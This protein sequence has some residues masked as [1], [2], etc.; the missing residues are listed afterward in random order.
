M[1]KIAKAA[2]AVVLVLA[3]TVSVFAAPSVSRGPAPSVSKSAASTFGVQKAIVTDAAGNTIR[4][5]P[6]DVT[7]SAVDAATKDEL[8]N[9]ANDLTALVSN[10]ADELPEGVAASD[11]TVKEVYDVKLSATAKKLIE[12]GGSVRIHFTVPGVKKGNFVVVLHKG[13]DGWEAL[14]AKAVGL[15]NVAVVMDS[16]SPV[17]I[18][19]LKNGVTIGGVTS[20]A[21]GEAVVADGVAAACAAVL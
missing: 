1:K 13:A 17:A 11:L 12:D 14:P 10:L 3:M 4:L 16:F 5:S 19:T 2:L 18:V 15:N 21:T 8:K 7:I 6:V 20:P 9:A